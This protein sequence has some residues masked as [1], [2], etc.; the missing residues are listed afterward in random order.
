M[1]SALPAI[2]ALTVRRSS[3]CRQASHR[4]DD[5]WHEGGAHRLDGLSARRLLV[6]IA[7]LSAVTLFEFPLFWASEVVRRQCSSTVAALAVRWSGWP[8]FGAGQTGRVSPRQ[9]APRRG[10]KSAKRA[11]SLVRNESYAIVVERTGPA[12]SHVQSAVTSAVGH[13]VSRALPVR[14]CRAVT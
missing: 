12:Q 6:G 10:S 2:A 14:S 9:T 4:R 5:D 11:A 3:L 1:P 7:L 8:G 13:G